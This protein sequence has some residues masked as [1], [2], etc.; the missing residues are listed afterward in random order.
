MSRRYMVLALSIVLALA[1]NVQAVDKNP[2]LTPLGD[3]PRFT[4]NVNPSLSLADTCIVR[5][6]TG[7]ALQID[8]WVWG[9]EL[10]KNY[11]D[12][13]ADGCPSPY[14][15][16]IVAV[17]MPMLFHEA[18]PLSISVDI[19]AADM[20]NPSCPVPGQLLSISSN[21]EVQVPEPGLYDL[22]VP[23]DSPVTVNGPFFAGFF[24]GNELV[25]PDPNDPNQAIY[26]AAVIT[27][28]IPT[29][30]RAY[31]IWD[32]SIGFIDLVNNGIWNFPGQLVLYAAGIPGGSGGVQDPPSVKLLSPSRDQKLLGSADVWAWETSGSEIIDYLSFS[33]SSDGD[34]WT[35]FGR[36]YDGTMSLRDGVNSTTNGDGFR[37]TWDF[38]GVPE[39][40]YFVR[41]Q[42]VDTLGRT[43]SDSV[44]IFLEPTPPVPSISSPDNGETICGPTDILMSCNDEN[45]GVISIST[46]AALD[47][48]SVEMEARDQSLYGDTDYDRFDGNPAA[49]GEF[50]DY[51]NAPVAVALMLQVWADRG[52][53]SPIREG[54]NVLPLDTVVERLA[55]QFDTRDDLGTYDEALYL[56][57]KDYL[58]SHG[59]TLVMDNMTEPDYFTLRQW[60]EE[61]ERV[62]II[63]LGGP[64]G[65]WLGVDGFVGWQEEDGTWGVR[66]SDPTTG[67][68]T[69]LRMRDNLGTGEIQYLGDWLEI[70]LMVSTM[71]WNWTPTRQNVG[72]DFSGADGW[73]FAWEPSLAEGEAVFVRAMAQDLT[74]ISGATTALV[75]YS[76]LGNFSKGDY[77]GDGS[78][79]IV[80]LN[81]LISFVTAGGAPPVGTALRGDANCDGYVNITDVVYYINFLFGTVGEPCY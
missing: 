7:L 65:V 49:A 28:E 20:T 67:L 9:N 27:D 24:I 61:E 50:G 34:N 81:Y 6:D 13:A 12:P 55:V 80:D 79:N 5:N 16:T 78:V 66:V 11:I 41:V 77:N 68:R 54:S 10:Y 33:Y 42:A 39:G 18:T 75:R 8:G 38:S 35:E 23:L 59:N 45:M 43:A 36:D 25:Y 19:E 46:H 4:L 69:T 76:C 56:R 37:L 58:R 51:Y 63:A 70:D 64:I 30:C 32:E 57:L 3:V 47:T 52:Y 72:I 48:M 29:P 26:K 21:Y 53:T 62:V 74:T 1:I 2:Q 17:N 31:N 73:A 71:A 14:P 22:W 40:T 44:S 60:V 15:F